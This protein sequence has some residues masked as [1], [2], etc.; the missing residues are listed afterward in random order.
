MEQLCSH[1][2]DFYET[3]HRVVFTEIFLYIAPCV[4]IVQKL[5]AVYKDLFMCVISRCLQDA[6]KKY[7]SV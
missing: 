1:L 6:Y 7:C 4:K 2:T 5:N 3:S